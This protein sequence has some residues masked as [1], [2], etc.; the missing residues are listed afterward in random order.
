MISAADG[1]TVLGDG[2]DAPRLYLAAASLGDGTA[3]LTGGVVRG[4]DTL[5]ATD[6]TLRVA[7]DASTSPGPRLAQARAG[8][9]SV[10]MADGTVLVSGGLVVPSADRLPAVRDTV[11]ILNA[12]DSP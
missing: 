5:V 7:A 6:D 11:E 3:L 1:A 4:G 12:G 8:H 10:A 9:S 2:Q